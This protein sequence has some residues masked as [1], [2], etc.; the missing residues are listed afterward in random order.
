MRALG[1]A[2]AVMS[3]LVS[4]APSQTRSVTVTGRAEVTGSNTMGARQQALN[5]AFRMAVESGV[6][7]LVESSTVVKNAMLISDRIYSKAQG[8]VRNYDVVQ[9][10][11][12]DKQYVVKITAEVSMAD[13]TTDLK[14]IG[15][16]QDIMGNPKIMSMIEELVYDKAETAILNED[17]S[18]SIAIEQKLAENSFDLVD[19]QQVKKIRADELARMGEF[20]MD[21]LLENDEMIARIA[22]KALE[23]GA[24]YLLMGTSR[25][26]PASAGGGVYTVNGVFKCKVVDAS[27]G[28][29]VAVTQK[30]ESGRGSNLAQA[31]MYAGQR[32]GE[33]AAEAIIPQIVQNWSK[34]ANSGVAYIVKVYGITSYGTQARKLISALGSVNGVNSCNKRAW[35]AKMG[36]IEFDLAYKGGSGD[37]LIDGI[38]SAVEK[39]PELKGFDLEEQTGN[40]LNFRIKK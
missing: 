19:A 2:V 39:V 29:K 17:P 10:G 40:N 6:G 22:Q 5:A 13:L 24:Q 31:N 30:S 35:D 8:Y 4:T 38:F 3:L 28:E 12:Q 20:Y 25:L 1:I 15:V 26:E 18:A 33:S 37:E 9:E 34:R 14:S 7:V 16:L 11:E 36:R 23:Y 32:A 27:T 21:S